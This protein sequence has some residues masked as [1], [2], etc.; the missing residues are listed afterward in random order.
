M[1]RAGTRVPYRPCPVDFR[2]T[3]IRVGWDGIEAEIGAH[4]RNIRVWIEQ[5]GGDELRQARRQYLEDKYRAESGDPDRGVPGRRPLL[6]SRAARHVAG[7]R[8]GPASP[9]AGEEEAP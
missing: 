8:R 3:F 1:P 7:F 5:C 2:E 4:K 9:V 6:K